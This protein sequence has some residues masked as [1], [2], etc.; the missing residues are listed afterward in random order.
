MLNPMLHQNKEGF[1]RCLLKVSIPTEIGN[2]R[3]VDGSLARTIES[4]LNDINPEAAY[5]ARNRG[6]GQELWCAM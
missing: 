5:F 1:M 4:I 2:E 3:V 6:P